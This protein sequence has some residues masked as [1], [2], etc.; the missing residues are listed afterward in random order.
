MFCINIFSV[1]FFT[2]MHNLVDYLLL[3]QKDKPEA[4]K[5]WMSQETSRR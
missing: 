2:F 5:A 1:F 3:Y 4:Y